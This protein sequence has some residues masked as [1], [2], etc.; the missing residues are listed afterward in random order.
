[1][2]FT[3]V[4]ALGLGHPGEERAQRRP[5]PGRVVDA[6][7]RA[8][9][10]LQFDVVMTQFFGDGQQLG[11]ASA[12]AFHLVPG[13]DHPLMR[14]SL[15]DG[16]RVFHRLEELRPHLTRV[17]I[18]SEKIGSQPASCRASSWLCSSC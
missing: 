16:A 11:G 18:F 14:D 15:F 12:Q 13:E 9:Q 1:M 3:D 5:M 10:Q 6:L 2:T 4:L 17:L 7:Q 8:G